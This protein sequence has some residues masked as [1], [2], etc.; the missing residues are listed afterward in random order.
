MMNWNYYRID[1]PTKSETHTRYNG[2][3][4]REKLITQ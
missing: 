4:I 3:E 2:D 1:F